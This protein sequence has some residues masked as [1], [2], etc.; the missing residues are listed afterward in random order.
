MYII[1]FRQKIK[2]NSYK[3]KGSSIVVHSFMN[4]REPPGSAE[5]SQ[6]AISLLGRVGV[7][8]ELSIQGVL[9]GCSRD[10]ASGRVIS[11]GV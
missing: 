5:I 11:L 7:P 6:T 1:V 9:A 4:S 10:L 2:W 3:Q 8:G